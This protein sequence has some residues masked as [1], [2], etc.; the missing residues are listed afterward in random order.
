[1]IPLMRAAKQ[2]VNK[3]GQDFQALRL[4]V[5]TTGLAQGA[6]LHPAHAADD[7]F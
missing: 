7:N 4:T 6:E 3:R 2:A 1:M 5:V